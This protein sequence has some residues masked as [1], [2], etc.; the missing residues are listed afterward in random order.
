MQEFATIS[1]SAPGE[2]LPTYLPTGR[3]NDVWLAILVP[4]ESDAD[5]Y[6]VVFFV[7]VCQRPGIGL[8]REHAGSTTLPE[9]LPHASPDQLPHDWHLDYGAPIG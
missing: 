4:N 5:F 1:S 9:V 8:D 6:E 7:A 2:K 3:R